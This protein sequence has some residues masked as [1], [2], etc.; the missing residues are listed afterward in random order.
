M[1]TQTYLKTQ[2][3]TDLI[4]VGNGI[5]VIRNVGES[6]IKLISQTDETDYYLILYT[7]FEDTWTPVLAVQ[8]NAGKVI[9]N[10]A[11]TRDTK[12]I[13]NRIIQLLNVKQ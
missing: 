12:A 6:R 13:T 11:A 10:S 5:E 3:L 1:D 4:N 2:L 8:T 9:A 7:S